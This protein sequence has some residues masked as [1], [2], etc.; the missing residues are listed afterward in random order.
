MLQFAIQTRIKVFYRPTTLTEK[1]DNAIKKIQF[2]LA[3]DRIILNNPTPYFLNIAN[4]YLANNE[5]R[6]IAKSSMVAPFSSQTFSSTSDI[7]H[8]ENITVVY[9]DGTGKQIQVHLP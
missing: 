9:I 5:S 4:I 7:N 6:S 8:G 1:P 2:H 3:K